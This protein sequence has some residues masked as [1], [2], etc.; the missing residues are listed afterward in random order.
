MKQEPT[1]TMQTG[2]LAADSKLAE[3][4]LTEIWRVLVPNGRV[5][6]HEPEEMS[7]APIIA[8]GST[9]C[10]CNTE[11]TSAIARRIEAIVAEHECTLIHQK[12]P[13]PGFICLG[14]IVNGKVHHPIAWF[15]S[16]ENGPIVWR[17]SPDGVL[18][19]TKV[20]NSLPHEAEA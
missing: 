11:L 16:I 14:L 4:V 17:R 12:N 18:M 10:D 1:F 5:L 2:Q 3:K 13:S 8:C 20:P 15:Q 7:I 6:V 19:N 9:H